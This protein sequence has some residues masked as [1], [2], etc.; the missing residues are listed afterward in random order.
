MESIDAVAAAVGCGKGDAL[1][2]EHDGALLANQV[3]EAPS[4]GREA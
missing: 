2:V 3:A 4:A 1:V